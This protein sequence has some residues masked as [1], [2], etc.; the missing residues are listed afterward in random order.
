MICVSESTLKLAVMLLK[1]TAVALSKFCPVIVTYVPTGPLGG[2]KYAICGIGATVKSVALVAV[3]AE[4]WTWIL[5]VVAPAGTVAV[6][7]VAE[8]T[9]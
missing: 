1:L 9:V 3:P 4:F 8:L 6:M 7:R 5:P 2:V